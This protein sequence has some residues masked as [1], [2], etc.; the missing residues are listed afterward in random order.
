[1]EKSEIVVGLDIGTT[2]ICTIVGRQNEHGKIDI[3][4]L[5]KTHSDGVS[6][7][8]VTNIDKTVNAIREA[9]NQA[10]TKS[11]VVIKVANIGIAGQHI[12]SL[13]HRGIIVRNNPDEEIDQNDINRLV[14]DMYKLVMQPGEEI[15]HVI[16]QE[17][18]VDSEHGIKDPIGMAGVRLE[19]NFHIITGQV[20]AAKNLYRCVQKSGLQVSDLNLEPIASS[21]SVLLDDEKEAGVALVDIGGGTT[22]IAIFKEGIIRHTAVVPLGGNIITED[23]KQGCNVMTKQAESLKVKHGSSL[24][25]ETKE[26]EIIVIPGIKGKEPK[27]ISKKNLA[28]II[29]S[30]MEEIFEHVYYEIKSSGYQKGLIGGIVLTGGGAQLQH[31]AQLVEYV[32]GMDTRVGHPTDHL[33]KGMAEEVKSPMYATGIG[34]VLKGLEKGSAVTG[35]QFNKNTKDQQ[36]TKKRGWLNTLYHRSKKWLEDDD[37]IEDFS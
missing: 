22:D 28:Y 9:I 27:E 15:I 31:I 32:T 2:K 24:A 21:E 16:P 6:R 20:T 33:A 13:Q 19:G 37:D 18:I 25:D 17:F 5:G 36:E 12:K 8:V 26:N 4:G 3:L 7:G 30:R 1:M 35:T 11:D 34:L 29:Q 14:N 10:S 23:I